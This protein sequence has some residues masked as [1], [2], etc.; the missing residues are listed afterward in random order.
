M[1]PYKH[2]SKV[3]RV[4]ATT[5]VAVALGTLGTTSPATAELLE[6]S[7][8]TESGGA[9]SFILDTSV[10][11]DFTPFFTSLS[12][13]FPFFPGAITN[14]NFS[15]LEFSEPIGVEASFGSLTNFEGNL[16]DIL[17]RDIPNEGI[18]LLFLL[19]LSFEVPGPEPGAGFEVP[20]TEPGFLPDD[21]SAYS[22]LSFGSFAGYGGGFEALPGGDP[23]A[24]ES[25]FFFSP[26]TSV[27]VRENSSESVPEPSSILGIGLLGFLPLK[28]IL[29]SLDSQTERY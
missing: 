22:S 18:D 14:F 23:F 3:T 28:R 11:A 15:G 20:G 1:S 27:A 10:P 13:P 24:A 19:S 21:P 12:T 9:G 17:I 7:F 2:P 16:L 29:S 6:F 8:S 5:G 26:V 4:A 25:G